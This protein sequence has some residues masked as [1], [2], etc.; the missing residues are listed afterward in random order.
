MTFRARYLQELERLRLDEDT[1][2]YDGMAS[3][4]EAA[5]EEFLSH[6][7]QLAPGATWRD[8]FPDI[9]THWDLDDPDSWTHP[10]DDYALGAF[11]YPHAP[12]GSAVFA[13]LDSSLDLAA[14]TAAIEKVAALGIPIYGAGMVLD[15][16][17]PHLYVV[18]PLGAPSEHAERLA[19]FLREQSGLGNA[20]PTRFE[21]HSPDVT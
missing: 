14:G 11:D 3:A 1:C 7:R 17:A 20:Y 19:R 8:V 13:G 15:R 6:V 10:E 18:L 2:P 12:R 9:P 4:G 16:G 5:E 21:S